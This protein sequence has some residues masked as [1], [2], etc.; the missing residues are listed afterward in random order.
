MS[1]WWEKATGAASRNAAKQGKQ[2]KK[3]KP[4]N[5]PKQSL[6]AP[7]RPKLNESKFADCPVC[8]ASIH[9]DLINHHLD[10]DCPG[11][12]EPRRPDDAPPQPDDG[13]PPP[14]D[15]D[16]P[17]PDEVAP[18]SASPPPPRSA[19]PP[20]PRSA[21]PPPRSASPPP[22]QAAPPPPP[23]QRSAAE[24]SRFVDCP[25]CGD[26]ILKSALNHHLDLRCR[27]PREAGAGGGSDGGSDG[28]S[29]AAPATAACP[30][31][32]VTVPLAEIN[33]HIDGGCCV[34]GAPAETPTPA[35]TPPPT[36]SE[37][38]L[39]ELMRGQLSC[40]LCLDVFDD[41]AS[42]P[43][44]HTFCRECIL[45]AFERKD[46]KHEC[47]ICRQPCRKKSIQPAATTRAIV[48]LY[49]QRLKAPS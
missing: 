9:V 2:S 16:A 46:G 43:C 22:R 10:L 33:A 8:G 18:R 13:A 30:L 23:R 25:S 49:R 19:S 27:G 7:K 29:P 36:R 48:D 11:P 35:E 6:I 14:D 21:S 39:L 47:P 26:S 24:S 17:P 32:G 37:A 41:P 3:L 20:P 31:C 38:D 45:H 34:A 15:S 5:A 4:R 44:A 42:L 40:P 1:D 12:N 28:G